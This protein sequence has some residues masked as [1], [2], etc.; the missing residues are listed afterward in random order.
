MGIK[1][2]SVY[3]YTEIS[4][5]R[6]YP[7]APQVQTMNFHKRV[8]TQLYNFYLQLTKWYKP[9]TKVV[10]QNVCALAKLLL[11]WLMSEIK[12]IFPFG[13]SAHKCTWLRW[14]FPPSKFQCT[15]LTPG[16]LTH[17]LIPDIIVST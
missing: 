17:Q 1:A 7:N 9:G 13:G 6:I 16:C 10:I 5:A 4:Q 8:S 14:N 12:C 15:S 11:I 3:K 2:L